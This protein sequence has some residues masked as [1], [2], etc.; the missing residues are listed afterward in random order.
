MSLRI[1]KAGLCDSIQDNGRH[2]YQNSGINPNG[3]M[4]RFSSN[5]ANALLGKV[6]H[7]AVLEFSFPGSSIMFEKAT[8]ICITG[9]SFSPVINGQTIPLNHPIYVPANSLLEWKQLVSGRWC[10]L[11]LA[12]ELVLENWLGSYSTNT[13]IGAGGFKGKF[14]CTGD[15]VLYKNNIP[16]S[17]VYSSE[18][19]LLQWTANPAVTI[20]DEPFYFLKGNEW[21]WLGDEGK[22]AL[23]ENGF[24]IS[25]QSDRMG[26]RLEA[27]PIPLRIKESL[28]SSP[29]CAGTVQ[30]LPTGQL[31]VLMAD[32]QTTGGYPRIG[33]ITSA[34]LSRLAQCQPGSAIRF[35]EINLKEAE[36]KK[37]H[38]QKY[39][40]QI[41]KACTFKMQNIIH[42]AL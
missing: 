36:Q 4:D 21:H 35:K 11:A 18:V 37:V 23:H 27:L 19:K 12:H 6:L 7:A 33:Y 40:Q 10:Y 38:L 28:V 31:I 8:I 3:A 29:V 26:Y 41:K 22:Q 25:N 14:F 15:R 24:A 2:G 39:L 1:T 30:H 32:H 20:R 34:D 9:A 16:F 13:K 42:G 5:L 17:Q